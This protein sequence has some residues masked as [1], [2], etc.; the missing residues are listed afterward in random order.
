MS[1]WCDGTMPS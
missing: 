1:M